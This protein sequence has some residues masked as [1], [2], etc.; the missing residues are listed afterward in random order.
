MSHQ[1]LS[2]KEEECQ[3]S[4]IQGMI[5]VQQN[6]NED[7]EY[8]Y[9]QLF[10]LVAKV[11]QGD[12]LLGLLLIFFIYID[13]VWQYSIFTAQKH[14][15]WSLFLCYEYCQIFTNSFFIGRLWWLLSSVFLSCFHLWCSLYFPTLSLNFSRFNECRKTRIG[16]RTCTVDIKWIFLLK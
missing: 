2:D 1:N 10:K 4:L 16:L 13:Y 11:K 7:L 12:S 5:H 6:W 8:S 14:L 15:C 3:E 9:L